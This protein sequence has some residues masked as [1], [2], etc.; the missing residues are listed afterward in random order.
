MP[1]NIQY[2][3]NYLDEFLSISSEKIRLEKK[4]EKSRIN[5]T[6]SKDTQ[7]KFQKFVKKRHNGL[8]KGPYSYELERAMLLYLH[9]FDI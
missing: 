9:F 8:L 6:I 5:T 1:D 3:R 4:K 2:P 7:N